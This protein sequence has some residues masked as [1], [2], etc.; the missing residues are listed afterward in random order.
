MKYISHFNFKIFFFS[1]VTFGLLMSASD[2]ID[3]EELNGWKFL[4]L[5]FF[6][7]CMMALVQQNKSKA[8][9]KE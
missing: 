3:G 8:T 4:F 2:Y 1:G 9:N 7:G 6:F 5:S